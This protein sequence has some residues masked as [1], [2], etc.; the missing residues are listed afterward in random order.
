MVSLK[1]I[2][3]IVA[4]ILLIAFIIP[5]VNVQAMSNNKSQIIKES[6]INETTD[7]VI[8]ANY[9]QDENVEENEANNS[10]NEEVNDNIN[11][12]AVENSNSEESAAEEEALVIDNKVE[13]D[14]QDDS[15]ISITEKDSEKSSNTDNEETDES[16]EDNSKLRGNTYTKVKEENNSLATYGLYSSKIDSQEEYEREEFRLKAEAVEN[17]EVLVPMTKDNY[18]LTIANADGSYEF[19]DSYNDINIAIN[20]AN[21]ISV[22]ALEESQ[23][24]AVINAS[25]KVV[26]STNQMARVLRYVD[27][28]Y[29]AGNVNIYSDAARTNAITYV[30]QGYMDDAPILDMSGTSAKVMI[31]GVTGWLNN[32]SASGT[33]DMVVVPLN[34]AKN[35]SYYTVKNGELV[36]FISYDLVGNTGYS[37]VLGKA[38]TYL[39]EGVRYLSYDGQYFYKYDHTKQT[40]ITNALNTLINDYKAGVRK[41]SINSSNPYYLYYLYLP[42]RSKTVYSAS[43][44]NSY[45][46]NHSSIGKSSKLYNLGQ[47]FKDVETKYGVNAIL[48]LG[49]AI[50]ES[51]YG[52]SEIAKSKNNLFGLQ[53]YDASPGES[54]SSFATP[55]D[56][57]VDFA[58]NYISRGYADPADWRYYG[59]YL[60]NKDGG[61]NVKYA[62]D[63]YWGE[64]AAAYA[65]EID[66][67]LSNGNS[68]LKDTNSNQIGMATT[69]NTVVTKNGSLLYNV[70]S[71]KNQYAA[72]TN[73]PFVISDLQKVTI[74]GSECYEIYPERTTAVGSGGEKNKFSGN[75][76]WNTKGYIKASNIKLINSYIPQVEKEYG[77]DRY[78]TAVEL[79]KSSFDSSETVVIA[80]GG[81]L[82][83]GLTAT[84]IASY[85]E[86]PIL[87]V[88]TSEIP[89][90]TKQEIKRLGAKDVIIIG[91]TG[92]VSKSIETQLKSLG[93]TKI[94]RLG[95]ATR[96]ETALS[97]AKYIDKNMYD[98]SNIIIAYGYGEADALSISP[99]SGRDK[100]PILL[101]NNNSIPSS[102]YSFL[103]GESLNN[104]YIVGG[105]GVVSNTV[106]NSINSITKQ[107]IS[108]N[109]LGGATR[110]ET[111]AKV[112]EKFYGD[113]IEKVYVTEGGTLIDALTAGPVAALSNSPVVLTGYDLTSTQKSVLK[114]KTTNKIVQVGGVVSSVAVNNLKDLLSR[115]Q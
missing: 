22:D 6:T 78:K 43:N 20:A 106:L 63:P 31:S 34:Q 103:K 113:V 52:N 32:N 59:G 26:Y 75:Y 67:Y 102:V 92:V 37:K 4:Q 56:S 24:P 29:T 41:N 61:A 104:A 46:N 69:N 91:G 84:P 8:D 44:L 57:V 15:I 81:A 82:A 89:E 55:T 108:G 35:P 74:S 86:A 48:A 114:E 60:G 49:I 100:M 83:D 7:I 98:V 16:T 10:I 71:N 53:A 14:S 47:A 105:T 36:H 39:S 99:V 97:V 54:A 88:K 76:D 18:E 33:Y 62:S 25:G 2:K 58:K 28:K 107:N 109:R 9:S 115:T 77:S 68:N 27:S 111:N 72:Y 12:D 1:K 13:E 38:P 73:T 23:Q 90:A 3:R 101:V 42:F 79:S 70:T 51:G 11:D 94:T 30:N 95:G 110:Y 45:L 65:Y 50:N 64:K 87:L 66:K 93:I 96:Y 40:S 5:N 21:S 80:N 85:Y 17:L 19:L 112:I